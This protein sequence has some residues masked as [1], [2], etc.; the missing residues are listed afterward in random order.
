MTQPVGAL[1]LLQFDPKIDQ[2]QTAPSNTQLYNS[3]VEK[4][5]GDLWSD[6]RQTDRAAGQKILES[7]VSE[8]AFPVL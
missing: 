2:R 8:M 7:R 4:Q 5:A 1:I 6:Y 3:S